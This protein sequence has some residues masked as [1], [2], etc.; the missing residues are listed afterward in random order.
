V[1][2]TRKRKIIHL[3]IYVLLVL[4]GA[5]M[6]RAS[7]DIALDCAP[8]DVKARV[9]IW[10][11]EANKAEI[12]DARK[13]HWDFQDRL[14]SVG[15]DKFE[16]LFGRPV[17][18]VSAGYAIPVFTHAAVGFS[19][20]GYRGG[21][22]RLYAISDL[23][24]VLMYPYGDGKFVSAVLVYLKIDDQFV[25]VRSP[26]DYRVRMDWDTSKLKLLK[27]WVEEQAKKKGIELPAPRP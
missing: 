17:D 24:G 25:P 22:P 21:S 11:T 6:S 10:E 2:N 5:A 9:K 18:K 13:Q 3:F 8:D 23:G 14:R 12:A 26:S 15:E 16:S 4:I 19:G 1:S 20:L 27:A 7:I